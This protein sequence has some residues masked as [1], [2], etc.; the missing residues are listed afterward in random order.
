MP[1]GALTVV[2]YCV[3]SLHNQVEDLGKMTLKRTGSPSHGCLTLTK[4]LSVCSLNL[5]LIPIGTFYFL[6]V[7]LISQEISKYFVKIKGDKRHH[8]LLTLL[9]S[10]GREDS[11]KIGTCQW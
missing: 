8:I 5:Y 11:T 4:I 3:F 7:R 9:S 2:R 10:C 6:N 1:L